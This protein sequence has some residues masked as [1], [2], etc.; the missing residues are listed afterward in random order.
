MKPVADQ[1]IAKG[2]NKAL[3]SFAFVPSTDPYPLT[4]D[5]MVVNRE[6]DLELYAVHDTPVH[7]P[8]SARGEL[9][10]GI[11]R[12]YAVLPAFH[13]AAPP[14]EPWELDIAAPPPPPQTPHSDRAPPDDGPRGRGWRGR[15]RG[16]F[17]GGRGGGDRDYKSKR[18]LPCT[19]YAQGRRASSSFIDHLSFPSFSPLSCI[20]RAKII[21]TVIKKL[22]FVSCV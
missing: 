11:G 22:I 8:W 12:S 9:A 16:G 18:Q 17:R 13:D 15:G 7:N 2:V 20:L 1:R 10:L 19:F 21:P 5:V 4:S 6:G 3:A 14:P